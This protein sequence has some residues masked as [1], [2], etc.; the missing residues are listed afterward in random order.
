MQMFLTTLWREWNPVDKKKRVAK[1]RSDRCQLADRKT[2]QRNIKN[3]ANE[4]VCVGG[5]DRSQL[6]VTA[7]PPHHT[8][9]ACGSRIC[10]SFLSCCGF[11]T[12]LII[13]EG[14]HTHIS[15]AYV[16]TKT[17]SEARM[18]GPIIPCVRRPARLPGPHSLC[19]ILFLMYGK[20][21][22]RIHYR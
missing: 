1:H 10:T 19:D 3:G 18:Q 21:H 5:S 16:P 15:S 14:G 9:A 20:C 6:S 22:M 4:G 12:S 7:P 13:S 8:S 17:V 2:S 11:F